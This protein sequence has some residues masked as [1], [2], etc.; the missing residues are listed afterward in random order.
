MSENEDTPGPWTVAW[1]TAAPDPR[2]RFAGEIGVPPQSL[3]TKTVGDRILVVGEPQGESVWVWELA[4]GE[5]GSQPSSD[6]ADVA[7]EDSCRIDLDG[8]ALVVKG[9]GRRIR[10]L[11]AA[12]EHELVESEFVESYRVASDPVTAVAAAEVDGGHWIVATTG[13]DA[14]GTLWAWELAP[15]EKPGRPVRGHAD[16]VSGLATAV[17]D[18]RRVLVS[19]GD[20]TVRLWDPA[21]GELVGAPLAGHDGA[22]TAIATTVLEER[23]HAV[24]LGRDGTTRLWD[25]TAGRQVGPALRKHPAPDLSGMSALEV[26]SGVF[27]GMSLHQVMKVAT[28]QVG[29]VPVAVVCGEDGVQVWDLAAGEARG[30]PLT[31]EFAT[32][33]A[34]GDLDRRPIAA[35]GS[36]GPVRLWDLGTGALIGELPGDPA[37][38]GVPLALAVEEV[39]GRTVIL[40]SKVRPPRSSIVQLWD[41]VTF[42]PIGEPM[43]GPEPSVTVGSMT[44]AVLDGR[45][46]VIGAGIKPP[47]LGVLLAWDAATGEQVG[48]PQVL[49]GMTAGVTRYPEGPEGSLAIGFGTDVAILTPRRP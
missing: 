1:S 14:R 44:V 4:T 17:V 45:P 31:E 11:D 36:I 26:I 34:T 19:A 6:F 18:G 5:G 38:D 12:T 32:V 2:L 21:T 47:G 29:G 30:E 40:T 43:E 41:P 24:T 48:E 15:R 23:P 7:G 20:T 13:D 8:R 35:T 3:A 16:D 10:V 27:S 42:L 33:V 22:V 39:G 49:P 9:Q 46:C 28:A 37:V 25:L